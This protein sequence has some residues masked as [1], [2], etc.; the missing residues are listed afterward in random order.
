MFLNYIQN[1]LDDEKQELTLFKERYDSRSS[2]PL[3]SDELYALELQIDEQTVVVNNLIYDK[4][5]KEQSIKTTLLG[6]ESD[7]NTNHFLLDKIAILEATLSEKQ[8]A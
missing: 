6:L 7:H 8:E 5:L 2:Q 3:A 4:A 1:Q